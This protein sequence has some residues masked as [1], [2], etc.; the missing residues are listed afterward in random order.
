MVRAKNSGS[1]KIEYLCLLMKTTSLIPVHH[2]PSHV[3]WQHSPLLPLREKG[4]SIQ[5]LIYPSCNSII[6]I[7]SDIIQKDQHI[8]D[9]KRH[10]NAQSIHT[11]LATCPQNNIFYIDAYSQSDVISV[12]CLK[13][14]VSGDQLYVRRIHHPYEYRQF[15]NTVV[16]V[17][18]IPEEYSSIRHRITTLDNFHIKYYL[19]KT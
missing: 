19:I 11:D 5:P 9:L 18:H 12:R 7:E 6:L 4:W 1:E 14:H 17:G 10:F 8:L 3:A 2:D 16:I 13:E 15:N